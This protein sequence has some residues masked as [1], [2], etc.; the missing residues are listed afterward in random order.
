MISAR[1]AL[2][3]APLALAAAGCAVPTLPP[4]AP[5]AL[6][7]RW[8]HVEEDGVAAIESVLSFDAAH[9]LESAMTVRYHDDGPIRPGCVTTRT[10]TGPT[11]SADAS[12]FATAGTTTWTFETAGCNHP[13]DDQ[14]RTVRT[15]PIEAGTRRPFTLDGDELTLRYD[16]G[17]APVLLRFER[18]Q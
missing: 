1:S 13:A 7:G 2:P 10:D 14:A 9:G 8:R 5:S 15:V 4:T 17:G 18:L 11:W 6:E 16:V 3:L 12:S